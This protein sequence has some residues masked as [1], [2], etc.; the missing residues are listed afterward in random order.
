MN[1]EKA[2]QKCQDRSKRNKAFPAYPH[3]KRRN[4]CRMYTL[5][6]IDNDVVNKI[7]VSR[8]VL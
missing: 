5:K 1:V 7:D 2:K 3:G 4:V 6:K 8:S